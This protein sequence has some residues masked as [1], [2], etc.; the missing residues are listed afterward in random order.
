M[1]MTNKQLQE[2]NL[3]ATPGR[4]VQ[5]HPHYCEEA[6]ATPIWECD[7]SHDSSAVTKDGHRRK[8]A[9]YQHSDDAAFAEAL[10]NAYRN[11]NLIWVDKA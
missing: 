10:V 2:L 9:S 6:K 3:Q 11:G 7:T 4:W 5:F 8:I 1:T